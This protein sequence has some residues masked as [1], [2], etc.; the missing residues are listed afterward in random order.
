LPLTMFSAKKINWKKLYELAREWIDLNLNKKMKINS[1]E[2]LSYNFPKLKL[3]LNVWS[4]AYIRSVGYWL[5]QQFGLGG[6]LTMLR[7]TKVWL[8]ELNG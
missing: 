8:F 3:K 5:G 1:Y 4:W 6:V 7:R 2:V